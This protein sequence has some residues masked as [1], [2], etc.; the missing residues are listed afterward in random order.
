MHPVRASDAIV[1]CPVQVLSRKALS[2]PERRRLGLHSPQ[3]LHAQLLEG[4]AKAAVA[5]WVLGSHGINEA[6]AMRSYFL[7]PALKG[8]DRFIREGRCMQKAASWATAWPPISLALLATMAREHGEVRLCDGN[9]E[10]LTL[11]QLLADVVAF[12]PD[13]V[14]IN[15]GFP[16]IEGDMEVARAIKQRLPA[17]RLVAFG[18][19]FTMLELEGFAAQSCLDVCIVGE[20]EITFRDLVA[21]LAAGRAD[22]SAIK[23]LIYR[24]GAEAHFT[25]L[26]PFLENLDTL[27]HPDRRLLKN[28]RYRLPTSGKPY[29]LVNTARGCPYHCT[30]CIV[31]SYYGRKLRKHSIPYVIEEIRQC[32]RDLG[33]DEFLFW[34]EVF[35]LDRKYLLALCQAILDAGLRIHW[36][37][38]TR[39]STLDDE[40]AQAMKRAGCYLVGLGIETASQTILDAAKKQQTVAEAERAV[41]ICKRHDLRTMGHFIFGLPGETRATAEATIRFMCEIGLDYV[42]CYAAVPY[43]KTELGDI[44]K[45]RGWITASHWSQ[46]DFGGASILRTDSLSPEEVDHFRR[47]AFLKFYL[48]P[49]YLARRLLT[50][51]SPRQILHLLSFTDWM[52][53]VGLMARWKSKPR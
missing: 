27:P 46:Y 1:P 18:V 15:T 52:D 8:G 42:Q 26:A 53:M 35:T 17:A 33:L 2:C 13:L 36:A 48:R 20:P 31:N 16:S 45:S 44:A 10:Q 50:D 30:F 22:L 51:V 24:E 25:G 21:A 12:N 19:Y 14:L 32:V 5:R 7:N 40:V 3:W 43:P 9:V 37:A 28:D 11:D 38:T 41:A 39:V 4:E 29:T 34:E 49:R 47:K 6:Y 23:G